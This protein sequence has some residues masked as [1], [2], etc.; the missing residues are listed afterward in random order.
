MVQSYQFLDKAIL[1]HPN[2]RV[3][4]PWDTLRPLPSCRSPAHCL[5]NGRDGNRIFGNN[6]AWGG[7]SRR[8]ITTNAD[9][10]GGSGCKTSGIA[11]MG[12][13]MPCNL[14]YHD[15]DDAAATIADNN[16]GMRN[17]G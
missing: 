17:W 8:T 6:N 12:L 11:G 1:S 16:D 14:E 4:A 2:V 10:F 15:N 3:V 5:D 13:Q 7:G 9:V